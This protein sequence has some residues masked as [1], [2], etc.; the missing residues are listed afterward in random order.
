MSLK[1]PRRTLPTGTG[2]ADRRSLRI[3]RGRSWPSVL[4]RAASVN[5]PVAL[6]IC[7]LSARREALQAS[8]AIHQSRQITPR[9]ETVERGHIDIR[10]GRD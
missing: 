2:E 9:K 5:R 10:L 3:G 8:K 4:Q 7:P 6:A 1:S